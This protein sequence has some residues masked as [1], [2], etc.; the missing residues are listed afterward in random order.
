MASSRCVACLSF[1]G[2]V[3]ACA[4]VIVGI[5]GIVVGP[6]ILQNQISSQ[7]PLNPYSDQVDSWETP[8]VPIYLQFW[9]WECVNP[10]EVFI[11][12]KPMLV[13]RG[14]FT[15]LEHRTKTGVAFNENYT[16]SYR[17]P[18]S[19]TFLRDK[20]FADEQYQV[21]MINT[22]FVTIALLIRNQSIFIQET[23]T[24]LTYLFDDTLFAKHTAGE[25]IWG[26]ED[27]ILRAVK[28][29]PILSPFAPDD[30]FGYFNGSNSTDDGLYT[31][32]TGAI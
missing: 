28:N 4:L 11:G 13:Q 15:Y 17:Q 24:F 27:P 31:V 8:P 30:R 18:I 22:P 26:Y 19:Y 21:T 16:I 29:N 20:S 3:I 14:P 1:F 6:D 23:F 10:D 9:L 2:L 5:V 12:G 32:F 25:W 7:L